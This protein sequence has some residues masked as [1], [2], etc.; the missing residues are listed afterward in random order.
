MPHFFDLIHAL[1]LREG[2]SFT[3]FKL[4]RIVGECVTIIKLKRY[5]YPLELTFEATTEESS[6]RDLLSIINNIIRN[7]KITCPYEFSI[8]PPFNS[9]IKK[10]DG[11]YIV[12]T[13]GHA[14]HTSQ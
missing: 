9:Q 7:I 10:K 2:K 6:V 3:T 11:K 13:I 12:S 4:T 5:R 14:I 1:N 8:D